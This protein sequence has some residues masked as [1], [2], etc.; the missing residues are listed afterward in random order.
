MVFGQKMVGWCKE[1]LGKL[2]VF[3]SFELRFQLTVYG[4]TRP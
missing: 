2:D 1:N 4:A 3:P